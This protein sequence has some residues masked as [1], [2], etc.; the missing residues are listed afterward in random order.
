[1]KVIRWIQNVAII[2]AIVVALY[3]A[4]GIE[5]TRKD[6]VS[7]SVLIVLAVVTLL[8]RALEE[9]RRAE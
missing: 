9:E 2:A 7:A 3:L 5:I 4:D 8:S 6:A 1:M